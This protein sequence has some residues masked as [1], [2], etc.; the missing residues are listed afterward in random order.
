MTWLSD[1]WPRCRDSAA[2]S[3]SLPTPPSSLCAHSASRGRWSDVVRGP[4][5]ARAAGLMG[6][7]TL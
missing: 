7:D 4:Y 5:R 6:L 3:T 2:R 1:A